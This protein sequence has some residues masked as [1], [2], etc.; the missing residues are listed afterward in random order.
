[1]PRPSAREN[2]P[3]SRVERLPD[4]APEE[5]RGL[6]PAPTK[7][8][9]KRW[10]VARRFDCEGRWPHGATRAIAK[11][12]AARAHGSRVVANETTRLAQM[13]TRDRGP[14][15]G[16]VAGCR[17][18]RGARRGAARRRRSPSLRVAVRRSRFAPALP[19]GSAAA[20]AIAA[21]RRSASLVA[22]PIARALERARTRMARLHDATGTRIARLGSG[23]RDALDSGNRGGTLARPSGVRHLSSVVEQRFRKP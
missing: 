21:G 7:H 8:F 5:S 6:T 2:E 1:M 10:G 18:S 17:R 20:K 23:L 16:P 19:D 14:R 22:R 15:C 4:R 12:I 3:E 13:R 9:F 11:W